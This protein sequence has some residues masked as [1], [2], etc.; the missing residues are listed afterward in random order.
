MSEKL[1][2]IRNLHV[3]YRTMETNVYAVNGVD[4]DLEVGETLGLVGETGAGKTTTALS[5]IGL[6][7]DKVGKVTEGSIIYD[8]IDMLNAKDEDLRLLRGADISMIFQDPMSSLNPVISIG[9]Q[10]LEVLELHN[11]ENLSKEALHKKVD[12]IMEMVGIP[13]ER[14]DEYPHQFSGGM[15]QRVVIAMALACKPK[16]IL[17][18]EPTTALDVTIQAQVLSMMIDLQKQINTSMIII[19][20]DLG[21]VAQTCKKVAVMYGGMLVEYGTVEHIFESGKRHPYTQGLFDSIPNL[22]VEMDRLVP[23]EG[24]VVDPTTERT[25]CQFLERCKYRNENCRECPQMTEV[26]PGH[27]IRCRLFEKEKADE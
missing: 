13:P 4:L 7:P 14:K 10:I 5:V 12:E 1:L 25:C 24:Q 16:L 2:E 18:D 19:T 27:F 11:P 23:I 3:E 8:G 26:E 22:D 20:H 15:K 9:D 21:I 17:A 6:L